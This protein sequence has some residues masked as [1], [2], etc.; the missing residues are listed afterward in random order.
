MITFRKSIIGRNHRC[1]VIKIPNRKKLKRKYCQQ[2]NKKAKEK[3][4]K[5]RFQLDQI[6][7]SMFSLSAKVVITMLNSLFDED[8]D[9]E[10]TEVSLTNNEFVLEY[11][12]YDII[13]GDGYWQYTAEDLLYA[14]ACMTRK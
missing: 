6:M 9:P 13:R 11:N 1:L 10:N 8:Y 5:L 4:E 2:K 3:K 7:K 14:E 12:D